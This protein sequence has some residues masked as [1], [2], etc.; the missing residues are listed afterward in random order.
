MLGELMRFR[1]G[2]A[3]AGTHG[4]TTTTSLVASVLAEGGYEGGGAM[5]YFGWHGPFKPGVEELTGR[6]VYYGAA[7]TEAPNYAGLP[8]FVVG[9]ANSA[10][11]GAMFFSRYASKVTMLVPELDG[12]LFD[13]FDI[14]FDGKKVAFGYKKEGGPFRI[15][16][17]DIDPVA[18]KMVPGSLRQLTFGPDDEAVAGVTAT[19]LRSIPG[20][21][22]K[23]G[24]AVDR[25]ERRICKDLDIVIV[26][27]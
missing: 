8:M 22:S 13:R 26:C 24:L 18:G 21:A 9:G 15:Y 20:I 2:I 17:I 19:A 1:Q 5:V 16:E 4:K 6:G 3:V 7:L 25:F 11:Q 14:S 27:E 10:G 12:G 23:L